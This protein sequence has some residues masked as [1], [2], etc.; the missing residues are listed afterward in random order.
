MSSAHGGALRHEMRSF[1]ELR[2]SLAP[3]Q[4][5]RGDNT[6]GSLWGAPWWRISR[7]QGSGGIKSKGWSPRDFVI[8]ES[9][10]LCRTH[11]YT[12][13]SFRGELEGS[14]DPQ[15]FLIFISP[16]KLH[17]WNSA[18]AARTKSYIDWDPRLIYWNDAAASIASD[19]SV[20]VS[21]RWQ[22]LD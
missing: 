17:L 8:R 7:I 12:V 4:A 16:C 5:Y 2:T 19:W 10:R 1:Y 18:T 15:G 11:E 21:G 20:R 9:Q 6:A 22:K 14:T 13:A 3:L